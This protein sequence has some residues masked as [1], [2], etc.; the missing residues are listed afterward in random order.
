MHQ[1]P[2]TEDNGTEDPRERA[3]KAWRAG[4][5]LEEREALEILIE[6]SPGDLDNHLR[7]ATV[8]VWLGEW[9]AAKKVL[10]QAEQ[11]GHTCS[12]VQIR[13]GLAQVA[14]NKDIHAAINHFR[15][16]AANDPTNAEAFLRLGRC[17]LRIRRYEDAAEA[18]S[19]AIEAGYGTPHVYTLQGICQAGVADTHGAMDLFRQALRLN[20][21]HA[22]AW[23]NLGLC[24]QKEG[25]TDP[26]YA[27]YQKALETK[28]DYTLALLNQGN[29]LQ[30]Q[31]DY[32][33]AESTFRKLLELSAGMAVAHF[34]LGNALVGQGKDGEAVSSYRKALE[35]DSSY[36]QAKLNLALAL[37]REGRYDEG[38]TAYEERKNRE[39]PVPTI[40]NPSCREWKGPEDR[41]E[42]LLLV[43][44]QGLGDTIHFARYAKEAL[45]WAN[46]VTLCAQE[47]LVELL[48]YSDLG[49]SI[50]KA[51]QLN[52]V[53]S[54]AWRSLLSVPQYL[55][56][57]KDNVGV[58]RPYLKA[59]QDRIT[60]WSN[61]LRLDGR[62]LIGVNW[63]GNPDTE[64]GFC[65]G[66]S[67][68]LEMLRPLGQLEGVELVSLQKGPGIEQL[69]ECSFISRFSSAQ[70][71]VDASW[72]FKE[73]AA[74]IMACDI[75]ITSDTVVAHLAGALGKEV[76]L[77]LQ[78]VAEWRWGLEGS[79]TSWYPSMKIYRQRDDGDW[80]HVVSSVYEDVLKRLATPSTE[81]TEGE[82]QRISLTQIKHNNTNER[83]REL[84]RLAESNLS[85]GNHTLANAAYQFLVNK[86]YANPSVIYNLGFLYGAQG[87]P[88][89][90][91][92]VA[93]VGIKKFPKDP[94]LY[95]LLGRALLG[96]E[97][98][99]E[100]VNILQK[101]IALAPRSVQL[102]IK[103]GMALTKLRKYDEA[104]NCYRRALKL[105]PKD[106][107]ALWL[108]G[109]A[110]RLR[111]DVE[112][113]IRAYRQALALDPN[114]HAVHSCLGVALQE[115]GKIRDALASH[116]QAIELMPDN[117]EYRW[118]YA[119]CLLLAENYVDGWKEYEYRWSANEK[120]KPL[121]VPTTQMW[122]GGTEQHTDNLLVVAEQGLG[123]TLQFM[124]YC[125]MIKKYASSVT[126]VLQDKLVEL[127]RFSE[128]ADE[129]VSPHQKPL[130]PLGPWVPLLSLPMHLGV[131]SQHPLAN[132]P[133]IR[134]SPKLKEEWSLKIRKNKS[135]VIGINWQG[136]PSTESKGT[137]GGRSLPLAMFEPLSK[138]DGIS[139]LSLQK[140]FGSEQLETCTFRDKFIAAQKEVEKTWGFMDTAAIVESCDL[141]ITTDTAMAHLAGGI[142]ASTWVLLK[143]VPD[144][145][146]GLHGTTTGWYP[147][148][149]LFRQKG[150]G[151]WEGVIKEVCSALRIW[152]TEMNTA[153]ST[154]VEGS[155]ST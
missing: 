94:Q 16:A 143:Y 15:D 78:K 122:C 146:W 31:K 144:W 28:P 112:E 105:S 151:D 50:C 5:F 129:V 21:H 106:T 45:R 98:N 147:S 145:R 86:N 51:S 69:L 1:L 97:Q 64:I 119:G 35:L 123:D 63:Q 58:N 150:R 126:V 29:N 102:L 46:N 81:T 109:V 114:Y 130:R 149:R 66:R 7:L 67:F 74:I 139:F 47:P 43:A 96:L 89:K 137:M 55:R 82:E 24:L 104:L 11:H 4:R 18:L 135:L 40:V 14:L 103:M 107:E 61:K 23:Y 131:T 17:Y 92:E 57:S 13:L 75:V 108:L 155:H 141:V 153:G 79:T 125:Q 148:M 85:R 133:Y 49:V 110:L 80:S 39:D 34:N 134:V 124:R 76:W 33:Q 154:R 52:S 72:C 83:M 68:L 128:I 30:E 26:A 25:D 62:L 88:Q 90:A 65:Q 44:E 101:G 99:E 116:K 20:P 60:Y 95:D 53:R 37:L 100:A 77:L 140:G 42:N 54:D 3:E 27:A 118:N 152:Q 120:R 84:E 71:L 121:V 2:S 59:P 6:Q 56:L 142:G 113:A 70:S 48:G 115:Q 111:G 132:N 127:A 87:D 73:T 91:C 8:Y 22:Q 32:K 41:V 117:A 9:E 19:K 136:N 36:P 12:G 138:V 93:K 38:F 10:K